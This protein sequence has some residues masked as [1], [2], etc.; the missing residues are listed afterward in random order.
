M[1]DL[2]PSDFKIVPTIKG[3]I[4]EIN[5]KGIVFVVFYG[6]D[7]THSIPYL[8]LANTINDEYCTFAKFDITKHAEYAVQSLNT[9]TPLTYTP[10][11][12]IYVN[13]RPYMSYSGPPD[14]VEIKKL[15]MYIN[16]MQ[17]VTASLT[18]DKNSVI[19]VYK[20]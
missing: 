17:T 3:D 15:I 1:L 8:Q 13:G 2:Q 10:Y 18:F 19:P 7:C 20:I 16:L 12:V 4:V 9:K 5:M 6:T 14:I 11:I